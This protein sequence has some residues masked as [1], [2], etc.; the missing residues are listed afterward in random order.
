MP[1]STQDIKTALKEVLAQE[2]GAGIQPTIIPPL[3]EPMKINSEVRD[4]SRI[5]TSEAVDLFK[6]VKLYRRLKDSTIETSLKRLKPF[7]ATFEFLPLDSDLIRKE[8]LKR[9]TERSPRYHRNIYDT[10]VDLYNTVGPKLHL[11]CN[12]MDE[13]DRPQL[14]GTGETIPNPLNF[15]WLSGLANAGETDFEIAALLTELGA[16]W[17]P[18]EFRRIEAIDVREAL[19]KEDSIILVRGKERKELTPVLPKTL[20]ILAKLTLP[21]MGDHERI[22]RNKYGQPMGEKAHTTMIRGLYQRAGIPASFVPYDLRDTFA[23]WVYRQ[24]KDWFITERLMRHKL[25]G[26]GRRYARY[27]LHELCDDL[28]RL[29]PWQG[30]AGSSGEGGTRTPTPCGT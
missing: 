13:I 2:N 30:G 4:I 26:E 21:D 29:T 6:E 23:S 10:L 3:Q 25:P 15:K 28:K 7:T 19:Y 12:P 27:P 11:P 18:I 20:E 22:I 16:G 24:S 1:I 5:P 9:Y 17:R 14:D 8:F